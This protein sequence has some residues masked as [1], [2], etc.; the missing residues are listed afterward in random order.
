MTTTLAQPSPTAAEFGERLF[1]AVLGAQLVQAVYL[2][3]RLGFYGVLADGAALTS[4]ELAG[5]TGCAERY[6]REWLEHQAV[7]GVLVVSDVDAAAGER[8]YLLPPG[9]VEVLTDVL[10][11]NHVLPLARIIAGLGVHMDAL[12][13]AYRSGGGV[14]WAELGADARESQAAA[15]RPL[16]LGA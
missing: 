13:A 9:P 10:S 7:C 1:G 14:S 4:A 11:P 15:N 3:D 12:A 2:G 8:R 6:A 16:F 5:R